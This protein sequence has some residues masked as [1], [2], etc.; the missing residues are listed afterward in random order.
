MISREV[1]GLATA[2]LVKSLE[3]T[4]MAMLSRYISMNYFARLVLFGPFTT[5]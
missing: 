3:V 1:P 2:M 5:F 4:P